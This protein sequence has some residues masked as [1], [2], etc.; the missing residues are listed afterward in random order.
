MWLQSRPH[1]RGLGDMGD[2]RGQLSATG[3]LWGNANVL[4]FPVV[5]DIRLH[6]VNELHIVKG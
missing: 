4:K 6:K 3:L 5:M 2:G 1:H